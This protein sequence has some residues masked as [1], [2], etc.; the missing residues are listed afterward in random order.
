MY[1]EILFLPFYERIFYAYYLWMEYLISETNARLIIAH[2]Q[3]DICA[4][5]KLRKR[6]IIN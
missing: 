4:K 3:F 5:N 1:Y 2:S 6:P